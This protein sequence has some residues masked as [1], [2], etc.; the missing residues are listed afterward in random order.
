MYRYIPR[1]KRK[2][3]SSMPE[4]TLTPLID[5]S[6]TLLIIF[7]ITTPMIHNAIKVNLPRGNVKEDIGLK[8]E[9]IVFVDEKEKIYF[10]SK[11][12]TSSDELIKE[13]KQAIGDEKD[14]T[15][16]LKAD[17]SIRYGL[18]TKL[19]DQMKEIDGI[20]QVALATQKV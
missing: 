3:T 15:V 20:S 18:V 17:Q 10:N 4:I 19:V 6:L 12:H 1:R 9:L 8:Q 13:L 14:K 16:H 2:S 7:M 11:S 5:T